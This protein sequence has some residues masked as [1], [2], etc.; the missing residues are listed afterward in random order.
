MLFKRLIPLLPWIGLM[1]AAGIMVHAII[2]NIHEANQWPKRLGRFLI[3]FFTGA[4]VFGVVYIAGGMLVS[5][6][7][8]TYNDKPLL[9]L[10]H[11]VCL[12]GVYPA[13]MVAA[14]VF[15]TRHLALLVGIFLTIAVHLWDHGTFL[16]RMVFDDPALPLNGD[17][18]LTNMALMLIGSVLGGEAGLRVTLPGTYLRAA[19]EGTELPS[20]DGPSL[21]SGGG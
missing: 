21:T 15:R 17:F 8:Y 11:I 18:I 5:T 13:A 9:R 2:A 16:G 20:A 12:I 19:R 14:S 4:V 3:A 1:F 6:V 10:A 7:G